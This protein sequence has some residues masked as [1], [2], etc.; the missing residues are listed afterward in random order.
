[1]RVTARDNRGGVGMRRV[2]LHVNG[3]R[4]R[5][6]GGGTVRGSWFGFP[7]SATATPDRDP[8]A[9][10]G[11]ERDRAAP[12]RA[13]GHAPSSFGDSAAP[14]VRWRSRRAARAQ[15]PGSPSTSP[16]AGRPACAGS[17]AFSPWTRAA[18]TS[19]VYSTVFSAMN[20]A[21]FPDSCDCTLEQDNEAGLSW[22]ITPGRGGSIT[23][24]LATT[25]SPGGLVPQATV[26]TTITGAPADPDQRRHSNVLVLLER[27]GLHVRVS[28]R[29]RQLRGVRVAAHDEPLVD[30][31]HTFEVRATGLGEAIRHL[32]H[33]PSPSTRPLRGHRSQRSGQRRRRRQPRFPHSARAIRTPASSAGSTRTRSRPA[34][35]RTRR[36]PSLRA[37]TPSS[38]GSR[39]G[40]QCGPASRQYVHPSRR[41]SRPA[42]RP[43]SRP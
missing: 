43:T 2:E 29:W 27:G 37:S 42:G 4:V 34:S 7:L 40:G 9:R 23:R 35:R 36:A 3:R 11:A 8:R 6:W 10:P 28:G 24:S 39:P 31:P 32:R 26:P 25:F 1:M 30:G 18:T 33:A 20:G 16:T 13:Q 38:S 21:D 5:T 17:R 19:D 14:R 41:E 15:P 12:R 22:T